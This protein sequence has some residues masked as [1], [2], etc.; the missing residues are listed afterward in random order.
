MEEDA[1]R[2]EEN[3]GRER[4]AE[5][6]A[7]LRIVRWEDA[8]PPRRVAGVPVSIQTGGMEGFLPVYRTMA[9]AERDHPGGPFVSITETGL[10]EWQPW[11]AG[12]PG[13]TGE[14]ETW[15]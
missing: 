2:V 10:T 15:Q 9:E 3:A 14:E 12:S 8:F 6:V 11:L 1:G 13:G 5:Y 4:P 7:V